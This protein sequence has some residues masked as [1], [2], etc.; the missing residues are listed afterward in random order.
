MSSGGAFHIKV[1]EDSDGQ[2]GGEM[3]SRIVNNGS[4]GWNTYN[5]NDDE[6]N[7]VVTGDFWMGI[8]EFSS[9]SPFGFDTDSE[10]STIL[11]KSG[12]AGT[13]TSITDMGYNGN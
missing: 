2:P 10:N 6:P 5:I 4:M 12:P 9:S 13:W 8:M 11:T 1:W 3:Y 7:L